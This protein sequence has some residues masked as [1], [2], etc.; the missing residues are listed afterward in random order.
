MYIFI[1][2]SS[3]YSSARSYDSSRRRPYSDGGHYSGGTDYGRHQHMH[4]HQNCSCENSDD[5]EIDP[6]RLRSLI[7]KN[8][9][10]NQT[11]ANL[12][13]SIS[14]FSQL[15]LS[16]LGRY[17]NYSVLSNDST[18][19]IV[20]ESL[21]STSD[22]VGSKLVK[23]QSI[24]AFKDKKELTRGMSR[25][26]LS[27]P[28][29]GDIKDND[30]S[31]ILSPT[32]T[33]IDKIKVI[34]VL[35]ADNPI[36]ASLEDDTTD[37]VAGIK[38]RLAFSK[39][40]DNVMSADTSISDNLM[41][42]SCTESSLSSEANIYS[43]SN[44][45]V[46]GLSSF[47]NPNYVGFLPGKEVGLLSQDYWREGALDLESVRHKEFAEL[48]R[49]PPDSGIGL[50]VEMERRTPMD[51]QLSTLE[52]F[53]TFDTQKPQYSKPPKPLVEINPRP[54]YG[55]RE[56]PI[57]GSN[58]DKNKSTSRVTFS[59][60]PTERTFESSHSPANTGRSSSSNIRPRD[61][62]SVSERINPFLRPDPPPVPEGPDAMYILGG[63]EIGQL[64]VFKRPISI[65]KLDLPY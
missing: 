20:D 11:T 30:D 21:A 65:W 60:G 36:E 17:Y 8:C 13:I 9:A 24:H 2:S 34:S 61:S 58:D 46:N 28:N 25:D 44:Y 41:S 6:H 40:S 51:V 26:I 43:A 39:D 22:S 48:L 50:G 7:Q 1:Y 27:V 56:A 4:D 16:H 45:N 64:T 42:F 31:T 29:F 49:T 35:P 32:H 18:E 10:N 62:S 52:D 15:N 23:S 14:K 47:S 3:G 38:G 57:E 37:L 55:L 63:K 54:S 19:S 33:N 12:K 53:V 59:T 5:D